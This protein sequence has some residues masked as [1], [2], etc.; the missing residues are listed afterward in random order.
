MGKGKRKGLIKY[1]I[2]NIKKFIKRVFINFSREFQNWKKRRF[3]KF[4]EKQTK[5]GKEDL[6]NM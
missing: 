4:L 6:K 5:M 2:L 3:K 1:I